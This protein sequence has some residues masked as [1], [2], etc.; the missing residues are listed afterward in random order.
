[1]KI[2]HGIAGAMALSASV[3]FA[4][5][6]SF[7]GPFTWYRRCGPVFGDPAGGMDFNITQPANA[8][9]NGFSDPNT[10]W[11]SYCGG[12][13]SCGLFSQPI[14][15]T[16]GILR[17]TTLTPL[18]RCSNS[19]NLRLAYGPAY[20]D[21]VGASAPAG[22]TWETTADVA[23]TVGAGPQLFLTLPTYIG[24]RIQL[25]DGVHYGWAHLE[26]WT[27]DG[28]GHHGFVVSAWA[29]ESTPNTAIVVG[30]PP[31]DCEFDGLAGIT[32]QDFFEFITA[33]FNGD[34]AADVNNDWILSSQD[35]FDFLACFF[36]PPVQC[37]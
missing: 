1:M 4:D 20:G 29:Y 33:F 2:L 8:Q 31:C 34:D 30:N 12:L 13:T 17:S 24:V 5:V 28:M 37:Q 22:A 25:P 26:S 21:V 19:I 36:A 27:N 15:A 10:M 11:F 7:E 14:H 32:S 6:V 9:P 16:V 18:S 35:F 23:A 3:C